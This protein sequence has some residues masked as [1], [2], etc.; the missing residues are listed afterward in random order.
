MG[1]LKTMRMQ[2]DLSSPNRR[3]EELYLLLERVY[4]VAREER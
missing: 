1:T 3:T 4:L 2:L